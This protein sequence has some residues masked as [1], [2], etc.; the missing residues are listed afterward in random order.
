MV[1]PLMAS[2]SPVFTRG[3]TSRL[4]RPPRAAHQS[5]CAHVSVCGRVCSMLWQARVPQRTPCK[6]TAARHAPK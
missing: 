3:S 4:A 2:E 6:A 5:R 1:L